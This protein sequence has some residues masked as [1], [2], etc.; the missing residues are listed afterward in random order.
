M[1]RIEVDESECERGGQREMA[2]ETK[3]RTNIRIHQIRIAMDHFTANTRRK[4]MNVIAVSEKEG[5]KVE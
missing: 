2:Q 4:R 1:T 3:L 5:T